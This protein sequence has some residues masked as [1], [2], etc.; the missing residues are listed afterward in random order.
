MKN[1]SLLFVAA[2]FLVFTSYGCNNIPDPGF[3]VETWITQINRFGIPERMRHQYVSVSGVLYERGQG[4]T[5][6]NEAFLNEGSGS[7]AYVDVDDGVAPAIWNFIED[8]GPCENE[9]QQ[10]VVDAG[11]ITRY[12]CDAVGRIFFFFSV[13][14]SFIDVANPPATVTISGSG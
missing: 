9:L 6:D 11:E 1:R 5:G 7:D 10:L 13:S 14:P 3:R 12:E 4:A 8:N 2:I